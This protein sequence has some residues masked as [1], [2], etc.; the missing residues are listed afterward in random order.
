MLALGQYNLRY[1]NNWLSRLKVVLRSGVIVSVFLPTMSI[2]GAP[3]GAQTVESS[4]SG[5]AAGYTSDFTDIRVNFEDDQTLTDEERLKL[6][7]QA[8]FQSLSCPSSYK[9]EQSTA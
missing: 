2:L 6:M 4:E 8:F 9:L 7:D 5:A 1:M 3:S